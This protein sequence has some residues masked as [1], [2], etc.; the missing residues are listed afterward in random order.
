MKSL[1]GNKTAENLLMAFAGE[2]QARNH[3]TFFAS[4]AD[5]QGYKQI[6]NIFIE[7]EDNEKENAKRF[8]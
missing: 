4:V 6:K 8:Y 7:T 5:K 1:K 2:P 3:Y